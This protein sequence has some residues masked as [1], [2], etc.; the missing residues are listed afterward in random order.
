MAGIEHEGVSA[1]ETRRRA[2]GGEEDLVG[3]LADIVAVD[4][5]ELAKRPDEVRV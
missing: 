2:A 1:P 4:T 3:R 5:L